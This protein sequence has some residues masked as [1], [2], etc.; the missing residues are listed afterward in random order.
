[1]ESSLQNSP[2]N[3]HKPLVNNLFINND[4]NNYFAPKSI[5]NNTPTLKLVKNSDSK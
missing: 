3:K 2:Q 5:K 4:Q 1:M